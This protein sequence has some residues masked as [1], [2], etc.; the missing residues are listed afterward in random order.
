M[1]EHEQ[2][3]YLE[4]VDNRFNTLE[5]LLRNHAQ[6]IAQQHKDIE[7]VRTADGDR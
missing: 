4:N 2:Q 5:N 6:L 3:E 7:E 1:S